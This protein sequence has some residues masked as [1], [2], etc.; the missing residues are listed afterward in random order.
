MITTTSTFQSA[1]TGEWF[2]RFT[3][4]DPGKPSPEDGDS[5]V[6]IPV[7]DMSRERY[8]HYEIVLS[9]WLIEVTKALEVKVGQLL[10]LLLSHEVD[11]LL[12]EIKYLK[13]DERYLRHAQRTLEDCGNKV[14]P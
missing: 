1:R 11:A 14:Q 9:T 12:Q 4:H 10:G 8:R 7:S 2:V 6:L 5:V 13:D 3:C